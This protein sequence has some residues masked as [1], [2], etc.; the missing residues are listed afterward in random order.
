MNKNGLA[1]ATGVAGYILL[2]ATLMG[3]ARYWFG[4]DD[5]GI[6]APVLML[7]V[8]AVSVLVCTLLVGA[9][10]Y[11]LFVAKKGKEA[12]ALVVATTKWL[13]VYLILLIIGVIFW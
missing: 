8:L 11:K 5:R 9:E 10:P 2:V 12:L 6:L 13:I 1:Q 4:E 3:N 7:M